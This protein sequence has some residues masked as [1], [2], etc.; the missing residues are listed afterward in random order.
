MNVHIKLL[1]CRSSHIGAVADIFPR[2]SHSGR[3]YL[4]AATVGMDTVVT[5]GVR[6]N[7]LTILVPEDHNYMLPV[8]GFNFVTF[9]C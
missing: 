9:T 7:Q 2:V 6:V 8:K 3:Q 5:I 4:Q 1:L